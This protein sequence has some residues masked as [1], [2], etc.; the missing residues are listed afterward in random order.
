MKEV[1]RLR[2]FIQEGDVF[3]LDG[4]LERFRFHYEKHKGISSVDW[5]KRKL[6]GEVVMNNHDQ[7]IGYADPISVI[8]HAHP[9]DV[10]EDYGPIPSI[11][12]QLYFTPPDP[13]G[14]A[15]SFMATNLQ[16]LDTTS[17]LARA[18]SSEL[19]VL[20]Q[21]G[22]A[23]EA[24]GMVKQMVYAA[25]HPV[26]AFADTVEGVLKSPIHAYRNGT[27]LLADLRLLWRY[28]I[29]PYYQQIK[30]LLDDI[31][32]RR[33]SRIS[34][35]D[36]SKTEK[37]V[38]DLPI[39]PVG[40]PSALHTNLEYTQEVTYTSHQ[41]L[42]LAFSLD[43]VLDK[44]FSFSIPQTVWELTRFSFVVDW[45]VNV[46]DFIAAYEDTLNVNKSGAACISHLVIVDQPEFKNPA[47]ET[48]TVPGVLAYKYQ[49]TL[50]AAGRS[51]MVYYYR[52][53]T[54]RPREFIKLGWSD[55]FDL[56]HQLDGLAL[57]WQTVK[58]KA[59]SQA[60]IMAAEDKIRQKQARSTLTNHLEFSAALRN[61]LSVM[62][63]KRP[64][65][66]KR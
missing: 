60:T 4:M 66:S 32:V 45:F 65:K 61:N 48:V 11:T 22:E 37:V 44:F 49:R 41:V 58:S 2:N 36:F 43:Q 63:R 12:A 53:V 52:P 57:G 5:R 21:I 55:N 35:G 6:S 28:G 23:R 40:L 24:I 8:L 25:A 38:F 42:K 19:D 50:T 13:F 15:R 9:V 51:Q 47:P 62:A 3:H 64:I 30:D 10:I 54:N 34:W 31:K 18:N 7:A 26:K 59:V 39:S 1:V 56:T 33:F 27:S 29:N 20:T 17:A 46:G 16:Q 14:T